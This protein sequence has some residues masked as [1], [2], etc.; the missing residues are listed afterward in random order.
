MH[1][2][3]RGALYLSQFETRVTNVEDFRTGT[4]HNTR[5]SCEGV[6]SDSL[7]KREWRFLPPFA[8][9][10]MLEKES[11][12]SRDLH[13]LFAP[14]THNHRGSWSVC[15]CSA[16]SMRSGASGGCFFS[17]TPSRDVVIDEGFA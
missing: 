9:T 16:V 8:I 10:D 12:R 11:I 14:V 1:P 7:C 4:G 17:V 3:T 2:I 15:S 13:R 5:C 6:S